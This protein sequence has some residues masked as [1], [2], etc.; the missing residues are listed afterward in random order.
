V[1]EQ[2]HSLSEDVKELTLSFQEDATLIEGGM[3]QMLRSLNNLLKVAQ[4]NKQSKAQLSR[5]GSSLSGKQLPKHP[6]AQRTEGDTEEDMSLIQRL[7]KTIQEKKRVPAAAK[8][9]SRVFK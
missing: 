8:Q 4:S 1:A 3:S 5:P 2:L 9:P 7:E 6:P